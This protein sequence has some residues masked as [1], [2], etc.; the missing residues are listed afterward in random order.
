MLTIFL[1]YKIS[2]Y[3]VCFLLFSN[4]SLSKCRQNYRNSLGVF[5]KKNGRNITASIQQ[6]EYDLEIS[7]RYVILRA[8]NQIVL[9]E[10]GIKHEIF[11]K[12]INF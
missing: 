9:V 6:I 7:M 4:K 12:N 5:G 2:L 1:L 3:H 8:S 11:K 10:S